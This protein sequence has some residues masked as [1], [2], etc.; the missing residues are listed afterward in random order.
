MGPRVLL[1]LL[2]LA[3]LPAAEPSENASAQARLLQPLHRPAVPPV[4]GGAWL[5]NPVDAFILSRL[6]AAGLKP[7]PPADRATLLRRVTFDLTGLMPAPAEVEAFLADNS[8]GAYEKLVDRLLTSPHFGERWA[9]H[10]LDIVRYADTDGFKLDR[11]RPNAF[12]YRD[13]VI[14]AF[15][16]D[17]P[18]D[19][20]MRLQLAGDETE[21][22]HPDALA[23]SGFYRLPAEDVSASN[24][25]LVRQNLLDDVTDVF[26]VAFLGLTVGCARCH[27]HKF[28]PISQKDYYRLQAFFAPVVHRDLPLADAPT[29]AEHARREEA[30]ELATRGVRAE[31]AA[32]LDPLRQQLF[33]ELVETFDPDTRTALQTPAVLR[34]PLQEEL[35]TLAS[36]QIEQRSARL[37]RRLAPPARAR[38]EALK[39]R[40]ASYDGIK[41]PPLPVA[42]AIADVGPLAP[43]THRLCGGNYLRPR[44]EVFPAVPAFLD[45]TRPA[46]QPPDAPAG[47]T[48][49]RVALAEWL[50]RPDHP[51]TGRVIV[52]R[53]WQHHLG[54][55]IVGTPND[56]GAMA[57]PATHPELLD[58]LA[59][60]L[61]CGG[62]DLKR[63]HRLIVTSATYRQAS[64]PEQNPAAGRAAQFD[65]EDSLLWHARVKR[66]EAESIRD[67]ALQASGEL[68]VRLYGPAARPELPAAVMDS[69]YA[70]DPDSRPEDRNRRSI[71]VL[72][73]R[74]MPYPLFAAFDLP[75]RHNSCPAR[76]STI[77]APQAL[78]MLNSQFML[79]RARG[80]AARLLAA[81]GEDT[82][83]LVRGAYRILFG[84]EP[85]PDELV[86]AQRFIDR[87]ARLF[88][89]VSR[90]AGDPLPALT[91]STSA[92]MS[93]PRAAAVVDYCHALL[94]SAEFLYVD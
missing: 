38:Y 61:V 2:T 80:L 83:G 10:W 87:Q 23:A 81:H 77:T 65:P 25:R 52:N 53:I 93:A 47:N 9:Q 43:P 37:Y 94:N 50:R 59:T 21:P 51:L 6:G 39:K 29:R 24:F 73:R 4:R 72:A 92:S 67:S 85:V 35:A 56:F 46:F 58:W 32:L 49:R 19:R 7:S 5:R 76:A 12:R 45:G 66:R 16:D 18:Y 33:Q 63:I 88:P 68:N 3:T 44:E 91:G 22:N 36:H 64:D 26:G 30:W 31:I 89:A 84:R 54:R 40:L 17:L 57:D 60:E 79:A 8:A 15:N 41:P 86:S 27:D 20:F 1:T 70:W 75:D 13:W 74:N 34:T 78:A 90:S 42:A 71:Y 69:R 82:R 48:G 11:V 55:G 28:D 62:W 14:R